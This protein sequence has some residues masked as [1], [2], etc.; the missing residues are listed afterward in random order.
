MSA[1]RFSR[2]AGC[3]PGRPRTPGV[4]DPCGPLGCADVRV[5]IPFGATRMRAGRPAHPRRGGPLRPSGVRGRPRPPSVWRNPDAGREA[6][7][8]PTWRTLAALWGART[9]TSAFR[10]AQRGC[11]PGGPRTSD[12]ADPCGPLGCADVRVR[13]PFWR[14]AAA[15]R[16][17]RGPRCRR[18]GRL[19]RSASAL[20][21]SVEPTSQEDRT[22]RWTSQ[23]AMV[24]T[25][26]SP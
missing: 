9:S 3:G 18:P 13:I 12:V 23:R 5:R 15:G 20:Y 6:R 25:E 10:L 24:S 2:K 21:F 19:R 8:P 26:K 14:N 16:E 4:A 11:G 1:L 22:C 17:A 7:A